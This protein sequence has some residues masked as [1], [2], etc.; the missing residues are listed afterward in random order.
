MSRAYY[1]DAITDFLK[2]GKDAIIGQLVA[3]RGADQTQN[4][5]WDA[6]I[7]I[8][9]NALA[10]YGGRGKIYFEYDIPRLG[11]RIDV[12]A[13]ID[14]VIFVLEFKVGA[15]RDCLLPHK[16]PFNESNWWQS[17]A[18]DQVC[19]YALDLKN[20][21]QTSHRPIVAPVGEVE[22]GVLADLAAP[23]RSVILKK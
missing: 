2:L 10:H 13:V 17:H 16:R 5:A 9:Q 3:G 18:V 7:E 4:R 20:F 6:Q 8:M 12:L 1:S 23:L 22:R 14:N 19:D 21:H 11:R 15:D